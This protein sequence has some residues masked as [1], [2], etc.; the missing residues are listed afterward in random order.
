[1][2]VPLTEAEPEVPGWPRKVF[3]VKWCPLNVGEALARGR[4]RKEV[5]RRVTGH[6]VREGAPPVQFPSGWGAHVFPGVISGRNRGHLLNQQFKSIES[7]P[8]IVQGVLAR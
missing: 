3:W 2:E 7:I 4:K 6:W 8:L 5:N 1:M